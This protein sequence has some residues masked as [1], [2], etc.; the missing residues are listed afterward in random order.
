MLVFEALPAWHAK[1]RMNAALL[2]GSAITMDQE[3]CL[4]DLQSPIRNIWPD[5]SGQPRPAPKPPPAGS[6]P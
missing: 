3:L 5:E 4:S 2:N 6:Y 1:G